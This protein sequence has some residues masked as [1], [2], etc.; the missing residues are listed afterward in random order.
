MAYYL[1]KKIRDKRQANASPSQQ[2]YYNLSERAEGPTSTFQNQRDSTGSG[3]AFLSSNMND[4][5]ANKANKRKM[6]I[7]RWRLIIGLFF[8]CMVESLNQTI[9]ATALPFI[10]SDFSKSQ[11][12]RTHKLWVELTML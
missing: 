2:E 7:Y 5:G 10:G 6:R 9:V 3:D 12:R 1:Y 11:L 4:Q 8:P